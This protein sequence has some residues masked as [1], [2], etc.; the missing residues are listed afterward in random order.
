[1]DNEEFISLILSGNNEVL[2]VFLF[3]KMELVTAFFLVLKH[4]ELGFNLVV[5]N[6]LVAVGTMGTLLTF[7]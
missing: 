4:F 6:R 1:M 3:I 7:Y 5:S 2:F